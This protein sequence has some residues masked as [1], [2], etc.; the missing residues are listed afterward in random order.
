MTTLEYHVARLANVLILDDGLTGT[1]SSA[2]SSFSA[3]S[4]AKS[5]LVNFWMAFST[6]FFNE[7]H[8]FEFNMATNGDTWAFK[9]ESNRLKNAA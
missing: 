7:G 8:S 2:S 1:I 6:M 9:V 4:S 5:Q 3:S